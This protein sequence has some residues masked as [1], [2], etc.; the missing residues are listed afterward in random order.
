MNADRFAWPSHASRFA[1]RSLIV[2]RPLPALALA[3]AFVGPFAPQVAVAADV[4]ADIRQLQAQI[5]KQQALIA[6]QERQMKEQAARLAD[7]ERAIEE[8]REQIAALRAMI[9]GRVTVAGTAPPQP[10]GV[11]PAAYQA[12]RAGV[13]VPGRTVPAQGAAPAPA[14]APVPPTPTRPE[15][16]DPSLAS[17]GGVLTPRGVFVLEPG[18][19]YAYTSDNRLLVEGFTVVP[20]IT[21]G[22]L[23]VREVNRRTMTYSLTGRLGIT[24]RFEVDVK[25]PYLMRDDTTTSRTISGGGTVGAEQVLSADGSGLGDIEVGA[26]YQ[27]NSGADGWPFFI[28]NLR[29]KSRTGEDPFEVAVDPNTGLELELPTG[30]GFDALEPSITVIYPSDPVVF[31]GNARYIWNIARDVTLPTTGVNTEVDPGDGI[32]L[33]FGMGFGINER[34]SFSLGYEHVRILET[35]SGGNDVAGS[36]Y[37]I[38]SFLLGLSYQLSPRTSVNLGVAVGATDAAPDARISLRVPVRFQLF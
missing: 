25:L 13:F 22:N 27:L 15:I 37:D 19:E 12:P 4:A 23:D 16:P 3:A 28:A 26:H 29:Y 35:E 5:E 8:Q 24:D 2:R 36:D 1:F 10:E 11:V 32:G 38:G 34:S 21:V 14:P 17:G 33:S 7:Q 20:G 18:L 6:A 30:T 31:F 9:M